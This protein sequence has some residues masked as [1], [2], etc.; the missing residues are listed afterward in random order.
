MSKRPV[1][2]AINQSTGRAMALVK[3]LLLY[4]RLRRVCAPSQDICEVVS[5]NQSI[6][7]L[8]RL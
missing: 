3:Q 7:E 2:S 4:T 1:W 5:V 8:E 6:G